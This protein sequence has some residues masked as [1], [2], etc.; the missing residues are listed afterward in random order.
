MLRL[1]VARVALGFFSAPLPVFSVYDV[2]NGTFLKIRMSEISTGVYGAKML[3]EQ[4]YEAE[5]ICVRYAPPAL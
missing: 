5:R 4:E 3:F 2:T 1:A